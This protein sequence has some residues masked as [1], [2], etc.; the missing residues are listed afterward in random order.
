ML[1]DLELVRI[2]VQTLFT[3]DE[4]G[5]L[6]A[7][8]EPGGEPAPRFFLGRTTQGNVQPFR[9]DLPERERRE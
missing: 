5:R 7:I 2:Q 4:R 9:Y 3:Q 6:L 1:S 8:N